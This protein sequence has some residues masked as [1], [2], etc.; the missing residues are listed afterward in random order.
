[1]TTTYTADKTLGDRVLTSIRTLLVD[2]HPIV[3]SGI[4]HLLERSPDIIIVGEAG[5]GLEA[6]QMVDSLDP[7]V[8]LLDLELPGLSGIEVAQRLRQGSASA[9]IL[10]LS[11]HDDPQYIQELLSVGASGYIMKEEA[12]EFIIEAVLGVARGEQGW[13]SRR[14]AS[15]MS[16]LMRESKA[17]I[18]GLSPREGQVLQAI[19]AGKTNQE[20]GF[21]LGVTEKT[22]EKHI[23]GI[24]NKLGVATRVEAAVLAVREGWL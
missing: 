6:L 23:L 15:Q 2:D 18:R 19:V 12:P 8:I 3:R 10:V 9:R 22:V 20:I 17:S 21:A 24:F 13:I 14:V 7:D 16:S 11:A 4:R 1:M 5:D